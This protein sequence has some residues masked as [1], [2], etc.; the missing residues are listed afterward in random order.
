MTAAHPSP[1]AS[2]DLLDTS[3]AGPAAI[4]GGA[5]RVLGYVIGVLASIGSSAVLF[6]HL[7]VEDT[8]RYLTIVTLATLAAGITD[9]G[10][11]GIGVREL[12]RRGP[13]ESRRLFANLFGI[14]ITLSALGVCGA[15]IFALV[16][17]SSTMVLGTVIAGTAVLAQTTQDTF[18]IPLLTR[19][20]LGWVTAVDVLRQLVTA[21]SIVALVVAGASLL[22]FWGCA[23]LGGLVATVAAAML[24]R[25][26][27]PLRPAFEGSVWRPL[28]KDTLPFALAAAVG[29]VYYRLAILIVSLVASGYELGLFSA[30]YRVID[31][32]IVVPQLVVGASFPIIA[33]AAHT[34]SERFDYAT[35]RMLDVCFLLGLA[36]CIGLL[37]GAP[38][39]IR[40]IAGPEFAAAADVLR[41]QG[42]A[43]IGSFTAAVFGYALLGMHRYRATLIVN[44]FVLV[45]SAVLTSAL[46]S[47]GGATGAATAVVI[48]ELCYAVALGLAVWHGGARPRV[49]LAAA[50]RALLAAGLG[51]LALLPP[52]LPDVVRPLLALAVYGVA[53]VVLRA[54]PQEVLEEIPRGR[55]GRR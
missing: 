44:L 27:V 22:P 9:A 4:R 35:G 14:R 12:S 46:A 29:A 21:I 2:P 32:L 37:T 53:L 55:W 20:R 15:V 48:V 3:A 39:I 42:V 25:G 7:G 36:A 33:R 6:R 52:D 40:V 17:Y 8:G 16:G 50:P 28:L 31:V 38:F 1:P 30:S 45:F 43:L 34:D 5:V 13:E 10:L 11:S 24:V 26:T 19:L 47:S 51:A 49:D 23:V 18:A 41:I 54:I